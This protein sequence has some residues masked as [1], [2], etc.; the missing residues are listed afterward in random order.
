MSFIFQ[1]LIVHR[2]AVDFCILILYPTVLLS[3]LIS[4]SSFEN[5]L[6]GVFYTF[7]SS[8]NKA[9]YFFI[10]YFQSLSLLSFLISLTKTSTSMLN[11]RNN[12]R[13]TCCCCSVTQVCLT[14]HN[15]MDCSMPG[16]PVLHHLPELAQIHVHWVSDAIQPSHPLPPLLLLPSIFSSIGSFIIS[17]L[18]ASGGQSSGVSASSSILPINIQDWSPLGWTG[19]ISLQS[20]GLLKVFFSTTICKLVILYEPHFHH[21]WKILMVLMK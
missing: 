21:W 16:F 15:P 4:T 8:E 9:F 18:F 11:R 14:L 6:H 13:Y 17:N 20:K 2:N 12:R 19:W 1:F 10:I 3:S 7:M 5:R